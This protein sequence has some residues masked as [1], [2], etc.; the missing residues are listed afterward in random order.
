LVHY[1]KHKGSKFLILVL[2]EVRVALE[3]Y[4]CGAEKP[5]CRYIRLNYVGIPLILKEA[6][7]GFKTGNTYFRSMVLSVLSVGRTAKFQKCPDYSTVTGCSTRTM[8]IPIDI[9]DSFV[10][11]LASLTSKNI[12]SIPYFGSFHF[13]VKASPLGDNCMESMMVEIVSLPPELLKAI[14]DVGGRDLKFRMNFI[15]SN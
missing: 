5:P 4:A 15:I 7:H 11:H 3:A 8:D 9:Y 6:T 10:R 13:S 12:N 14:Y 1:E 2:K